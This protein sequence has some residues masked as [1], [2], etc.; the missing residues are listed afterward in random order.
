MQKAK[1]QWAIEGDENSKFFHGIINRKRINLA[2]KGVM[3]DGDWVDDPCRVKEELRLHFANRFRAPVD[4]RYK[5]N[6]TFPNKLQ[7]DQMATLESLVSRDEVRNAVWGCGGLGMV[8]SKHS[9]LSRGLA[10]LRFL[11]LTIF[12]NKMPS[13]VGYH[14]N[15]LWLGSPTENSITLSVRALPFQVGFGE[16]YFSGQFHVGVVLILSMLGS[17]VTLICPHCRGIRLALSIIREEYLYRLKIEELDL[18]S[19]CPLQC[20]VMVLLS[21]NFWKGRFVIGRNALGWVGFKWEGV[22]CVKTVAKSC[23]DDRFYFASKAPLSVIQDGLKAEDLSAFV[24]WMSFGPDIVSV[25]A[26]GGWKL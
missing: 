4:T 23:L 17:N 8:F 24:F 10:T 5:L 26:A 20:G 1:I 9:S 6:Y 7:P 22:F 16:I 15:A 13:L 3:V 18:V 14:R 2:I 21:T 12:H 19:H 25:L 11:D